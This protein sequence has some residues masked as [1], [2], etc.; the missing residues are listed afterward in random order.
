M[1]YKDVINMLKIRINSDRTRIGDMFPAESQLAADYNVS[2]NTLRKA[3][4]AL[5]SEGLIERKHGSGT[6]IKNKSLQFSAIQL[7]GFSEIARKSG[8]TPSSQL[9]KF[10]LQEASDE[11]ASRLGLTSHEPVFYAKRLRIIDNIPIQ[12][13]ETWLSALRFPDLTISHMRQSKFHYIEAICGVKIKGSY[14]SL[15]P[16]TPPAEIAKMLK[17]S[18]RDPILKLH[19]QA[20]DEDNNPIDYSIL[21]TN[22]FSL[23]V[24]Y[25]LPRN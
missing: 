16:I 14:E 8:K 11:I 9:I 22:T 7:D 20:M 5:E 4:Q 23:Q 13:E 19:T 25:Y 21:Y 18:P 17:V 24:K 10:E 15:I 1:V 2:R 12:L 3:L 6:M